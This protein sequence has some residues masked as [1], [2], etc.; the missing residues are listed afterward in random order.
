[1]NL[2]EIFIATFGGED[3]AIAQFEQSSSQN[4]LLEMKLCSNVNKNNQEFRHD[5]AGTNSVFM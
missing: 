2:A 5:I 4:Y 3:V 1:M